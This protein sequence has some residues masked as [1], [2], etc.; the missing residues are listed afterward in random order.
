M[1]YV[2]AE[3]TSIAEWIRV[4][5]A[6]QRLSVRALGKLAGV[7]SA[8]ISRCERADGDATYSTV[9]RIVRALGYELQI[10]K[11]APPGLSLTTPTRKGDRSDFRRYPGTAAPGGDLRERS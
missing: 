1:A 11:M 3:A 8:T 7:G 2:V 6:R 5:R 4:E 10:T 9:E